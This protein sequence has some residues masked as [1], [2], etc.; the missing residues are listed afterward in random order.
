MHTR[1]RAVI[2]P[3]CNSDVLSPSDVCLEC[4]RK[5][6]VSPRS[7]SIS[8]RLIQISKF[9]RVQLAYLVVCV[10]GVTSVDM[11]SRSTGRPLSC[12]RRPFAVASGRLVR[13]HVR[14]I[15]FPQALLFD[16]DGVLVDTERDGHRVAFNEAFQEKGLRHEWDAA[17]Y[18]KLL[19]IGGGKERMKAYFSEHA[20]QEPFLSITAPE[21]QIEYLKELHLCKTKIFQKMIESGQMPLRPG[22]RELVGVIHACMS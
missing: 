6:L 19:E 12:L 14:N 8:V 5:R 4:H 16:C 1:I 17:T 7:R 20:D 21:E 3:L 13:C 15:D 18:G 10:P 22:V 11:S 9:L 2:T